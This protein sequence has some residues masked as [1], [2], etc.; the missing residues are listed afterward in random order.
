M[1]A[2]TG[3][4]GRRAAQCRSARSTRRADRPTS[5]WAIQSLANWPTA[6]VGV[7][8]RRHWR[9]NA[10]PGIWQADG[11]GIGRRHVSARP[12]RLVRPG[13]WTGWDLVHYAA[14]LAKELVVL[15]SGHDERN[16]S[17]R[18]TPLYCLSR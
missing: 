8:H 13:A 6:L 3:P 4:M 11:H 7:D 5:S 10:G 2:D 1:V 9:L 16:A 15:S 17:R 18:P 12:L 14:S